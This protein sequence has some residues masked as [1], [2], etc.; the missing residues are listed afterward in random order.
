LIN[1]L[2]FIT[3]CLAQKKARYNEEK[4]GITTLKK[5]NDAKL[6]TAKIQVNTKK[7]KYGK[8]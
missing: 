2:G 3:L 8:I 4:T 5:E 6:Y 7:T 1:K